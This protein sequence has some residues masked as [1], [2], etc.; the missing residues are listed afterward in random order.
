MSQ[1][2]S[3]AVEKVQLVYILVSFGRV[4]GCYARLEDASQIQA[5]LIAK[6]QIVNLIVEPLK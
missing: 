2:S 5:T 4:V 3:Q 6:G 1:Q